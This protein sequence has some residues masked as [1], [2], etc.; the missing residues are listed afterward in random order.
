MLA[1]PVQRCHASPSIHPGFNGEAR[2]NAPSRHAVDLPAD[3]F[4]LIQTSL[5]SCLVLSK[6]HSDA[7]ARP[8]AGTARSRVARGLAA[9]G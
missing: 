7:Q 9:R 5:D 4:H 6:R 3:T 2:W 1:A 8:R